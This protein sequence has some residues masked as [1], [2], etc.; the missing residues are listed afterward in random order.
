MSAKSENSWIEPRQSRSREKVERILDAALS[1]IV[2]AGSLELKMTTV[3][4]R[5]GVAIGTLYQFFPSRSAL[6]GRL[7]AREMLPIDQSVIHV[8]S[9]FSDIKDLSTHIEM[10]M[11]DHLALVKKRPGLMVIWSSSAL[12]P[13]IQEADLLNT[14]QNAHV[15]TDN[16]VPFLPV[17]AEKNAVYATAL[18]I[19]HLWGSVIRLCLL[20]EQA[21]ANCIIKQYASMV[22]AHGVQLAK[23][24]SEG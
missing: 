18:L 8:L 6:I 2:E 19:C 20:S 9:D 23:N 3:A 24:V 13:A 11:L 21:E 16:L 5:A 14:R 4:K 7:F 15:L 1:L 12:D 17:N 10:Q 22:A